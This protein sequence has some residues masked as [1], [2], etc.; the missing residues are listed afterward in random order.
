MAVLLYHYT[1]CHISRRKPLF[2]LYFLY[3]LY[4][5][6]FNGANATLE[7]YLLYLAL[8]CYEWAPEHEKMGNFYTLIWLATYLERNISFFGYFYTVLKL[9]TLRII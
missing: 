3:R 7:K 2:Q 4:G 9:V 6:S 1:A 8:A 5:L